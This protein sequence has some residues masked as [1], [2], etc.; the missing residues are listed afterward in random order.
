MIPSM[1]ECSFIGTGENFLNPGI[2]RK[3]FGCQ[4]KVYLSTGVFN[5]WKL[6]NLS[7]VEID[8]IEMDF[9]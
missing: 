1:F 9:S 2:N 8:P 3:R 6:S 7:D 4:A 5:L